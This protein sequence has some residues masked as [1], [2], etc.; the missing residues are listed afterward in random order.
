M[1]GRGGGGQ[2]LYTAVIFIG[3]LDGGS[4]SSGGGGKASGG[5]GWGGSAGG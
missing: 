3:R 4:T 5:D 1:R 2:R